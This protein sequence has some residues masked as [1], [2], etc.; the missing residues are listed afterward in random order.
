MNST[1]DKAKEAAC[2]VCEG[3][4]VIPSYD[5]VEH[6]AVPVTSDCDICGGTG[7][8]PIFQVELLNE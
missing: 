3:Q 5:Y 8:L 7:R 6:I 1:F 2:P 4:G